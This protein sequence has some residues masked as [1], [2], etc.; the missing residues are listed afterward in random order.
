MTMAKA[1]LQLLNPPSQA[2]GQPG[3]SIKR[4]EL[5]FN[6]KELTVKRTAKYEDRATKKSAPPEYKGLEP[7]SIS[8]EVFLDKEL[9]GDVSQAVTTLFSCLEPVSQNK[10][11]NPTPPVVTYGWGKHTY[12]TADE[13]S[14]STK[15]TL[16]DN[17]GNP[18]RATCTV[19]IQEAKQAPARTNPTS[20]GIAPRSVHTMSLGDTLMSVA[21]QEYAKPAYWR[22]V[23]KANGIDDPQRVP[24]GTVLLLPSPQDAGQL[25]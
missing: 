12:V 13:K 7:G 16:F 5:T 14:V 9:C 19:D 23:A 3:G 20:G 21:W 4:I 8:V 1:Y 2:G 15:Y 17:A 22:A 24:L 18:I 10:Y 6:P 25:A 11:T